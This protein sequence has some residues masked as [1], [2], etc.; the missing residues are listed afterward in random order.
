MTVGKIGRGKEAAADRL[1][2]N[3][4]FISRCLGHASS[5]T[6]IP[7]ISLLL[8]LKLQNLNKVSILNII[9]FILRVFQD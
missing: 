7:K 6:F 2:A 5:R 8:C 4:A 1:I 3:F 9:I